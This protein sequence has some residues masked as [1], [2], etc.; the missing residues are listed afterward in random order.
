MA[1]LFLNRLSHLIGFA[2]SLKMTFMRQIKK[3]LSGPP[4]YYRGSNEP[5]LA[6]QFKWQKHTLKMQKNLFFHIIKR[7]NICHLKASKLL[8]FYD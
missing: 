5:S 2:K 7:F 1:V 8:M 6:P 3:K 4:V